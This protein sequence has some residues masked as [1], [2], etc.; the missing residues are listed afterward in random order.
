MDISTSSAWSLEEFDFSND[1]DFTVT[2]QTTFSF[3]LLGYCRQGSFGY[4]V[5]GCDEVKVFGCS[6]GPCANARGRLGR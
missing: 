3:E 4:A 5:W 1:P 2:A 6:E